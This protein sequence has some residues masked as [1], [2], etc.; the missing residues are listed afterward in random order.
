[1]SN[2][3]NRPIDA[4]SWAFNQ[5]SMFHTFIFDQT[6]IKS[7]GAF[8]FDTDFVIIFAK[9]HLNNIL[10]FVVLDWCTRSIMFNNWRRVIFPIHHFKYYYVSH[11]KSHYASAVYLQYICTIL[12]IHN[13]MLV[14]M[15][16]QQ[17]SHDVNP[18]SQSNIPPI[19]II[20]MLFINIITPKLFIREIQSSDFPTK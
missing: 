17:C 10:Y 14:F 19:R 11:F 4:I 9:R 13:L 7:F 1:M 12:N 20:A 5:F 2:T 18:S 6:M 8:N 15:K 3:T 16:P